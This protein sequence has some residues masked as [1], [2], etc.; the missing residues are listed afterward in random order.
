M[1]ERFD[2]YRKPAPTIS[3]KWYAIIWILLIVASLFRNVYTLVEDIQYVAHG[4]TA[5][6]LLEIIYSLLEGGVSALLCYLCAIIVFSMSKKRGFVYCHRNDFVYFVMMFTAVARFIVG[7]VEV[8]ALL[9]PT[10]YYYTALMGDVT[11]LP[12]ALLA[13]YFLV[14]K[15][16]FMND[17][18]AYDVFVLYGSTY[19][20]VQGIITALYSS[21]YISVASDSEFGEI[22]RSLL[23]IAEDGGDARHL[24][25]ASIIALAMFGA[26]LVSAIAAGIV[27]RIKAKEFTP[28]TPPI[29]PEGRGSDNPFGDYSDN[30]F[31]GKVFKE[32]DL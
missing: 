2:T 29:P 32:F 23:G 14:L 10:I 5:T 21:V 16:R 4:S 20:I 25:I 30:N 8:F 22:V 31:D 26:W 6:I 27:L 1:Q 3:K 18:T 7:L 24:Y 15:P 17:R 13:M 28:P 11:V 12:G 9:E 19:F